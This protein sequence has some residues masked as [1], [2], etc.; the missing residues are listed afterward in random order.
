MSRIRVIAVDDEP[1]RVE[2]WYRQLLPEEWEVRKLTS[3]VALV[4]VLE[5]EGAERPDIIVLD[6]MMPPPSTWDPRLSSHGTRTGMVLLGLIRTVWEDVPVFLFTNARDRGLNEAAKA[7]GKATVRT[8]CDV[9]DLA[10]ELREFI[11]SLST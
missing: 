4:R 9:K 5:T 11:T 2:W 6:V 8:K 3:A 7:A 10:Q 1:E